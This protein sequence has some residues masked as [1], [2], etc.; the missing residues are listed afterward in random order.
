[1]KILQIHNSYNYYGGEDSVVDEE[2]NLLEKNGHEV[3]QL[4]RDNKK[5]LITLKD[6]FE[7]LK[8]LSYSEY[9]IKLL[10]QKLLEIGNPDIVHIHNTFPLWT[11]SIFKFLHEK[12]IPII[13]TLHNYRLV[14]DT[15]KLFDK[16]YLNYGCFKNSQ[17]K[18]FLISK[19]I[20]KNK[21]L[22]NNVNK[23]ITLT[24]FTRGQFI[25]AGISKERLAVKPNFLPKKK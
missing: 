17:I 21:K 10:S 24:E 12:Q 7:A 18:T 15:L 11:Y 22:L 3:I 9:S 23:F 2:K 5:E 13:M 4:F 6:K 16:N 8:N 1:M 14:W 25:R 20:N 19:I